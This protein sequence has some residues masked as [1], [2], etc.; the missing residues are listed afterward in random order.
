MS[1]HLKII[2]ILK[3][4]A[5][6]SSQFMWLGLDSF[7]KQYTSVHTPAGLR[8]KSLVT[9]PVVPHL[10]VSPSIILICLLAESLCEH[11]DTW[12][13]RNGLA[14]L[15]PILNTTGSLI[16]YYAVN[17]WS[18]YECFRGNGPGSQNQSQVARV[19]LWQ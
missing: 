3:W 10:P 1:E 18:T 2:H 7:I 19:Y 11:H 14:G 6:L 8:Q 16:I 5:T 12:N 9:S 15:V 13:L 4:L 17:V